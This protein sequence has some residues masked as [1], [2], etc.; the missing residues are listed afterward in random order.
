MSTLEIRAKEFAELA[1]G[2]IDQRRKYTDEPYIKHP[3]AVVE[4]VRSV[5]H[6]TEMLAAAWLHDVVEDTG[7]QLDE[8]REVFGEVVSELVDDLTDVSLPSDGN[9]ATRRAID[10]AH[11]AAASP[12]AQ[13]IKLADIIDNLSGI[14]T[15]DAK[16]AKTYLAEKRHLLEVLIEGNR[17]LWEK[18]SKLA[19]QPV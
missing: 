4:L 5:P 3:A 2:R 13:T 6:T 17:E 18:A 8:I 1:H 10:H 12:E 15:Y 11:T 14:V 19:N 16:F 9:R 7:I